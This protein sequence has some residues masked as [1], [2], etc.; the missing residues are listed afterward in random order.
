M[1]SEW[2]LEHPGGS[3]SIEF[4]ADGTN[5]FVCPGFPSADAYWRMRDDSTV[6]INWGKYGEY[7]LRMAPDGESMTGSAK[8]QPENWRKATRVRGLG[9]VR[10]INLNK[11]GRDEACGGCK[12]G[13]GGCGRD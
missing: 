9:E 11:R 8:G 7:E 10:Y 3:F 5:S 1:N 13:C 4:R 6:Y 12:S 2:V